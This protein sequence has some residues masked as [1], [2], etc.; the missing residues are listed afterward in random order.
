[1]LQH[2]G[3]DDGVKRAIGEGKRLCQITHHV[4]VNIIRP[5]AASDVCH[6]A[7]IDPVQRC[8]TATQIEQATVGAAGE[9]LG[10][11]LCYS[12]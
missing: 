5:V 11:A 10:I 6:Q 4:H 2:I 1:M 12:V 3:Q 7:S 9:M 8:L